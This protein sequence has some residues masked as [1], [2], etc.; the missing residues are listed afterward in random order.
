MTINPSSISAPQPSGASGNSTQQQYPGDGSDLGLTRTRSSAALDGEP[1][2]FPGIFSKN[3][4]RSS[5]RSSAVEDGS[6]PGFR[7]GDNES[8][9]DARET[10]LDE[11]K[12]TEM[13]EI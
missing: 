10:S 12:R 4:K 6:Y 9:T 1:R 13:V 3:A 7:K 8:V 11:D 5:M 2:I